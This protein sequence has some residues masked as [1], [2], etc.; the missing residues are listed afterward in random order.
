MQFIVEMYRDDILGL[1]R[2]LN[3]ASYALDDCTKRE[4]WAT[5]GAKIQLSAAFD[6]DITDKEMEDINNVL[7]QPIL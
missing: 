3:N 6:P 7:N 5:I 1:R 4:I 2:A